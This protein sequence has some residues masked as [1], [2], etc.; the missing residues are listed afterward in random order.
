MKMKIIGVPDGAWHSPPS[1]LIKL[2]VGRSRIWEGHTSFPVQ[3][4]IALTAW[5]RSDGSVHQIRN[6]LCLYE[7]RISGNVT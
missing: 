6:L 3:L 7:G 2:P 1:S 5:G 4:L